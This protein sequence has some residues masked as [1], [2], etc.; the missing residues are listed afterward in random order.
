[1]NVKHDGYIVSLRL[2]RNDADKAAWRRMRLTADER[3]QWNAANKAQ[4]YNGFPTQDEADAFHASLPES[5][6]AITVVSPFVN[7]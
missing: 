5:L 3:A 2:Y 4:P 1:M 7:L 6:R